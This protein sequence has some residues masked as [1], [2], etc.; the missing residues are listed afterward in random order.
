LE[1]SNRSRPHQP[2]TGSWD[3]EDLERMAVAAYMLGLAR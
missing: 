2:A 3:A 1:A